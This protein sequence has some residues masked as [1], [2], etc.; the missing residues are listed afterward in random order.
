MKPMKFIPRHRV[1]SDLVLFGASDHNY[2]IWNQPFDLISREYF[3]CQLGQILVPEN[4]SKRGAADYS[5]SDF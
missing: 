5:G 2:Q 3:E 1:D 4:E